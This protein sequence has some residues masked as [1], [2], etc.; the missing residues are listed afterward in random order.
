TLDSPSRWRAMVLR[1]TALT[2]ALSS[3]FAAA[4]DG[5]ADS[6]LREFVESHCIDCHGN[7]KPKGETNLH[8]LLGLGPKSRLDARLLESIYEQ[9][10]LGKMPPR[11][12]PQ[13][14]RDER[15]KVLTILKSTLRAIGTI[16]LDKS[17][18]PG[19]GNYVNHE[20]LFE[21][22]L[23]RATAPP[24]RLWR[25]S[26]ETFSERVNRI[27]GHNVIRFVPVATFPVPQKGLK[28]PAFPYKGPAHTAKDYA[29]VH[30]FGLTETELLIGLAEELATAQLQSGSLREYRNLEPGDAKWARLL[31]EQFQ[32]LYSRDATE[33]ERQSL[34]ELQKRVAADSDVATGNRTMIA[35]TYLRVETLFR[36]EV[37]DTSTDFA[38][39]TRPLGPLEY[40]FAVGLALRRNGPPPQ[41]VTAL[42]DYGNLNATELKKR[43]RPVLDSEEAHGRLLRFMD[44]YF[45]YGEAV[46]VFK[47]KHHRRY[48]PGWMIE[49]IEKFVSR[50]VKRD[51]DVLKELLTSTEY[52]V[53]GAFNT[54]FAP[55]WFQ[56]ETNGHLFYHSCYN[57]EKKDLVKDPSWRDF[58]GQ[59]AGV[60]T[61]PAWL[62]A[63]SDN[64][65]NHA[66]QRGRW[67]RTKLLGG[68]IPDTPVEVD[69]RFPEDPK[70]TLREKMR[71]VRKAECW[72]CHARMDPLGLPFEQFDLWG[73]HRTK[74]LDRPVVTTGE[75]DGQDIDGPIVL[76]RRLSASRRVQQVFL[77]HVF[78]FFCG[79]NETL[80]DAQTL[81][82]MDRA[83]TR[84]SGSLKAAI[85]ELLVSDSFRRRL[86]QE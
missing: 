35:A 81:R 11:K 78:R 68:I 24:P 59:R 49:D 51:R 39:K 1:L 7:K 71:V 30:D 74:E 62:I 29:N 19:Y 67:I 45:E 76:L 18:L 34:F 33:Q 56:D 48:R 66:I 64:T 3:S 26:P 4:N 14:K 57:L 16:P 41:L 32:K 15:E 58:R 12:R 70:L 83:Y 13:P 10:E 60:L 2:I 61:H 25:Y 77:R 28:H 55:K 36:F 6:L 63:F 53:R 73:R 43:L 50:I 84:E 44:E 20:A 31:N 42:E 85:V 47:D 65:K 37:G 40:A 21:G 72:S 38:S 9:I 5:T 46:F 82:A 75:L 17:H 86:S 23:P 52:N 22:E 79:R 80:G 27:A 54:K 69:A 8:P